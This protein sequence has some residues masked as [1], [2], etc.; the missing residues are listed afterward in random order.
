[1]Q[2]LIYRFIQRKENHIMSNEFNTQ[3]NQLLE[4]ISREL[5]IPPSK[6]QTA[7]Q[8]YTS[9]GEWLQNGDYD[10]STEAPIIYPQG[11][12]R[13]GTVVRPIKNGLE[14][15][16][17]IDLVVQPGIN[18]PDALPETIKSMVGN[19]LKENSNYERMLDKEGRRC[20]TLNYAEQD[21]IGFHMDILPAVAEEDLILHQL[22][23]IGVPEAMAECAIAISNKDGNGEYSWAASN[24]S[25]YATWFEE[26]NKPAFTAILEQ[27]KKIL[28]E[29]NRTIF[30]RIED[31][32]D[33]LV[34]T[35]LQRVIQI[36]KRHRDERFAGLENE[37]DKPISMI[38]TT[39]AAKLYQNEA[40]VYSALKNILEKLN[41]HAGLLSP[42]YVLNK[43]YADLQLI[44]RRPDGTWLIPNPVNPAEN[45]ADRWHEN[46][47]SKAKAFFQWVAWVCTDL[48]DIAQNTD[49]NRTQKLLSHRFGGK[50]LEEAAKGIITTGSIVLPSSPPNVQITN[51][52]RPWGCR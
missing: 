21:G 16:Y 17:D 34:K 37:G 14:C 43:K 5:D 39:L 46:Q 40:D 27:A 42:G 41:A 19:R 26:I 24:P 3:Y 45:F 12:F 1:M 51:P 50:L 15:D 8:R 13:L 44:T 29:S 47:D 18:K 25:G 20:W 36:L 33:Q 28:F 7:V 35:P 32:P 49:F 11:S 48:I 38:I 31:V 9:V 6:Y 52:T 4:G 30:N 2:I 10:G 23:E 22:L